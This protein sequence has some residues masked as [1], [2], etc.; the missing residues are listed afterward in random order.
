MQFSFVCRLLP[1]CPSQNQNKHYRYPYEQICRH[2]LVRFEKFHLMPVEFTSLLIV[3]LV[4]TSSTRFSSEIFHP[5][6]LFGVKTNT[7]CNVL[8]VWHKF[9]VL[10][11]FK[12]YLQSI[13]FF[14]WH[15]LGFTRKRCFSYFVEQNKTLRNGYL[16]RCYMDCIYI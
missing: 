4:L 7:L 3:L 5:V 16:V 6:D 1:K 10:Y 9:L 2:I 12:A 14:L 15:Y 13:K 11:R 8:S